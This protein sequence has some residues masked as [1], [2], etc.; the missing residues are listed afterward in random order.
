[1]RTAIFAATAA[2]ATVTLVSGWLNAVTVNA[3]TKPIL[4]SA[5]V[6]IDPTAIMH[7][8]RDLPV[9]QYDAI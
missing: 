4:E 3:R 9:E 5:Q 7:D 1:M 2:L 6:S 8:V